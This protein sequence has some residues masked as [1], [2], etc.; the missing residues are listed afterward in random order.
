MLKLYLARIFAEDGGPGILRLIFS[1]IGPVD[2]IYLFRFGGLL[3]GKTV[4]EKEYQR[5]KNP[6]IPQLIIF[7][8]K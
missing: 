8:Q 3:L 6:K 1:E 2:D 4:M 5:K 7:F